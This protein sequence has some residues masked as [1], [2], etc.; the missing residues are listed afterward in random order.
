MHRR[1]GG[2]EQRPG[3]A[4]YGAEHLDG[5]AAAPKPLSMLT[6]TTPGAQVARAEDKA[7]WPF[8]ETP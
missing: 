8:A 5:R 3:S 2:G 4:R 6:V 1:R 7:A